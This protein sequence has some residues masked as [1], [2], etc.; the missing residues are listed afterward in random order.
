MLDGGAGTDTLTG[1]AGAD[2]LKGGAGTDDREL[3]RLG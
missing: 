1:G 2:V 3:H